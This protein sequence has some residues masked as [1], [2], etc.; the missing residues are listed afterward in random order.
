MF[1][2]KDPTAAG[3]DAQRIEGRETFGFG[4][5]KSVYVRVRVEREEGKE[6]K[7]EKD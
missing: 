7:E 3:A 5:W 2:T 4:I 1:V 6:S